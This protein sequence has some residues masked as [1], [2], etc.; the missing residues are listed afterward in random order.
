MLKNRVTYLLFFVFSFYFYFLFSYSNQKLLEQHSFRQ[1]QTALTSFWFLKDNFKFSYETP[2]VGYPW[3]IPY[4]FPLYQYIVAFCVKK[5]GLGLDQLGRLVSS[6]FFLLSI[7]PIIKIS[8][9]I[10]LKKEFNY[11]FFC[12]FLSSPLYMFWSRTFMIES[13]ALFFALMSSLYALKNI[14]NK[15]S[16]N[17]SLLFIIFSSIAILQKSTSAL[18]ILFCLFIIN[19]YFIFLLPIKFKIKFNN[20]FFISFIYFIPVLLGFIWITYTDAVKSLNIYGITL[21][22]K[23]LQL[24]NFGDF[25][26]RFSS[27]FFKMMWNRIITQEIAGF[28]G[29]TFI[30]IYFKNSKKKNKN[31]I[32]ILFLF[33]LF[34]I[35]LFTPLHLIHSYYQ[36][37][38]VIFLI[39]I[40]AYSITYFDYNKYNFKNN[41]IF[42]ATLFFV[43]FNYFNGSNFYFKKA[44]RQITEFSNLDLAISNT[45]LRHTMDSSSL[46]VYGKNWG[47]EIAY[48]SQRKT[49][50]VPSNFNGFNNVWLNPNKYMG[51]LSIGAFV[52]FLKDK[53]FN[54]NDI[55]S[56]SSKKNY[57]LFCLEP[58]IYIYVL[59]KKE[60]SFRGKILKSLN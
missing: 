10:N 60:I 32:L 44:R 50:M 45:I 26:Q 35:L 42:I 30:F 46:V 19:I 52:F 53:K 8:R 27:I 41:G 4:E 12:L 48:Y 49:F 17:N 56:F 6:I 39:S 38:C 18:P 11:V 36:Y 51:D 14:F 23:S 13:A 29:I 1:T 21:T 16:F 58:D 9:L 47:S 33:F 37:S 28:F 15:T 24:W 31:F 55:L 43:L 3:S 20:L 5:T 40:L 25:N 2:V 34:P 54:Y 22:S 7:I 57:G 59:N